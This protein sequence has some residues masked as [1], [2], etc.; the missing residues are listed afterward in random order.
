MDTYGQQTWLTTLK[1]DIKQKF[2]HWENNHCNNNG[3]LGMKQQRTVLGCFVTS[4]S[5]LGPLF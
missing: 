2:I 4:K 3:L 1:P 5:K